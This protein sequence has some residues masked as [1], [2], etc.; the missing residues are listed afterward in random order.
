MNILEKAEAYDKAVEELKTCKINGT[1]ITAE[2]IENIF[3]E[4]QKRDE[5][6]IQKNIIQILYKERKALANK[7][8]IENEYDINECIAYAEGLKNRGVTSVTPR[9]HSPKDVNKA[10]RGF[11]DSFKNGWQYPTWADLE[12]AAYF[13]YNLSMEDNIENPNWRLGHKCDCAHVGCHVNRRYRYCRAKKEDIPYA[14]CNEN[15]DM[16]INAPDELKKCLED[17][18]YFYDKYV[19]AKH[20]TQRIYWNGNNLKEVIEFTGKSPKFDKWFK[21]WEEYETYVHEHDNIIK[22]CN[23]GIYY[24]VPVG[25]WIVKTPD[26]HNVPLKPLKKTEPYSTE[27]SACAFSLRYVKVYTPEMGAD[28]KTAA[29]RVIDIVKNFDDIVL[30][31][32][33]DKYISIDDET[34]V[35][36]VVNEYFT[37]CGCTGQITNLNQ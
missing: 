12:T 24:D 5:S 30:L 17:P 37:N 13:G 23:D 19:K 14:Q 2:V 26:G 27:P 8:Q 21:T 25:S 35:D 32:F 1:A 18:R 16:Y 36:E 20:E 10:I 15:C 3:P 7:G 33:N 4:L 34:T 11:V 29:A 28:I 31:N 22:L 6:Q 9:K